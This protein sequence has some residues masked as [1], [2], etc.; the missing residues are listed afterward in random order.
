MY[1]EYVNPS[2]SE[3]RLSQPV[4]GL[5]PGLS[6]T[7]TWGRMP[8]VGAQVSGPGIPSGTT[9]QSVT[10]STATLNNTITAAMQPATGTGAATPM[11][12][13]T[14]VTFYAPFTDAQA[15]GLQ[16]D[17]LGLIAAEQAA[18]SA[19]GGLGQRPSGTFRGRPDDR[20]S[21]HCTGRHDIPCRVHGGGR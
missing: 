12:R 4:G 16:M 1:V 15:A 10:A 17:T 13:G 21:C 20:V 3:V 19:G 18:E 2:T 9:V 14:P 11:L 8:A 6:L 5:T 7:F